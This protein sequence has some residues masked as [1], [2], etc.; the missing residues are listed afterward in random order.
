MYPGARERETVRARTQPVRLSSSGSS[1]G[2]SPRLITVGFRHFST[3]T[4]DPHNRAEGSAICET[5][6]GELLLLVLVRRLG[7]SALSAGRAG[8]AGSAADAGDVF[9]LDL[10]RGA[11]LAPDGIVD[12]LA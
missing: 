8:V 3:S 10:C 6:S 2:E 11:V 9:G 1:T 4:R 5:A 12:F 7:R